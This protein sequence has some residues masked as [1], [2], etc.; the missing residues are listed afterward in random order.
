MNVFDAVPADFFNLLASSS[1]NRIYAGCLEVLYRQYEKEISFKIPRIQ[2]RDAVAFYLLENHLELAGD[3]VTQENITD[4]NEESNFIIRKFI[5]SGWILEEKDDTTFESYIVMEKN[6]IALAEFLERL[7]SP[8]RPEFSSYILDMYNRFF[9]QTS[10]QK[11]DLYNLVLKPTFSDAKA[12]SSSLK[13]LST[14]IKKTI[15]TM[16]KE[17]TLVSLT[18]NIISYCDGDFIK[19]YARLVKQQNIH[20]YRNYISEQLDK[21]KSSEVFEVLCDSLK[22]EENIS[23]VEAEDRIY[24]MIDT[25]KKFLRDDYNKIMDDIKQKINTYI[26]IAISRERMLK[27]KGLDMRG[28]VEQTLR[29]LI[30]SSG[31]DDSSIER[32]IVNLFNLQQYNFLDKSSVRYPH[33]RQ[34]LLHNV[35]DN[36]ESLSEEELRIKQAELEKESYNPYSKD[37][38]ASFMEKIA[39]GGEVQSSNIPLKEK[40]DLLSLLGAVAYAQENGWNVEAGNGYE[41]SGNYKIRKWKAVKR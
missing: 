18:E 25:T 3:D 20:L 17:G 38:M 24:E 14:S 16:L 6:G 35:Q 32:E 40:G 41:E 12:L 28:S 5:A 30:S 15:E 22:D 11:N 34:S 33:T 26:R 37:L 8:G 27:N 4:A 31:D 19:E 21:L 10:E 36:F 13:E 2:I 1:N 23:A 29:V 39:S 9:H 7:A